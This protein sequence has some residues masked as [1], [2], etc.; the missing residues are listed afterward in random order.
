MKIQMIR[1]GKTKGNQEHRY[2]GRTDESL[3]DESAVQL[4]QKTMPSAD[5]LYVSPLKRCLETASLLYS[6]MEA[7]IISDFREC[8]FGQFE[9]KNYEELNGNPDYQKFIDSMGMC[10]FPDGEDRKTFQKRCV[11]ALEEVLFHSKEEETIALVVHGGTIMAI[12]DAYSDPHQDYYTW[13]VK[14]AEGFIADV[15]KKD[16]KYH[17]VHIR[18]LP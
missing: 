8:E 15:I 12:L 16:G 17:F 1:H 18:P 7:H 2:V 13:Q 14:N 3:L 6:D 11:K 9:Y 4:K 5:R 10:G